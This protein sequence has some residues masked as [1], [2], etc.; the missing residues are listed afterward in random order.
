MVSAGPVFDPA[1]DGC[2]NTAEFLKTRLRIGAAEARRRLALA[3]AVLPRTGITGAAESRPLTNDTGLLWF[4][5]S[6]NV[7]MV[8]KVIDGCAVN[9][10]CD[11]V[12]TTFTALGPPTVWSLDDSLPPPQGHGI[13]GLL[14]D[15]DHAAMVMHLT[16]DTTT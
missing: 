5:D 15:G 3:D 7:E 1:D 10:R 16:G 4:F 12:R 11:S 8:I 13:E 6:A 14:G 9:G 2:R